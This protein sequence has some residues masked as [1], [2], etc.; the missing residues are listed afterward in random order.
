MDERSGDRQLPAASV[1]HHARRL[2]ARTRTSAPAT[3]TPP[4]LRR[5]LL[6]DAILG[7]VLMIAALALVPFADV[8]SATYAEGRAIADRLDLAYG[9][10]W[11]DGASLGEAAERH[12]LHLEEYQVGERTIAVISTGEP[13]ASAGVCYGLRI[14]GGQP[15]VAVAFTPTEGCVPLG[16]SSFEAAGTWTDVLGT[17]RVTSAWFVPALVLLVGGLVA[18]VTDA[19]VAAVTR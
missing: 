3:D 9:D 19:I 7:G 12:D 5:R 15:T 18:V 6:R 14:G 4:G 1:E 17:E 8:P 2:A 11:R 10:V 13:S 16:R